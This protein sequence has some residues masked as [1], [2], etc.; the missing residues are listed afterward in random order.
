M[1]VHAHCRIYRQALPSWGFHIRGVRHQ[2]AQLGPQRR[3]ARDGRSFA[4]ERLVEIRDEGKVRLCRK[5]SESDLRCI[6]IQPLHTW[7]FWI[8]PCQRCRRRLAFFRTRDSQLPMLSHSYRKLGPDTHSERW[9]GSLARQLE[10]P[11][12]EVDIDASKCAQ[13]LTDHQFSSL[14]NGIMNIAS[15]DLFAGLCAAINFV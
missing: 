14:A 12:R 13:N 7:P 8:R 9:M 3:H 2:W 11:V 10:R 6:E 5:M 15:R 4:I 1:Q